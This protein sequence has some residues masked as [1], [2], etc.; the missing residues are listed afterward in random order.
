[1]STWTD[2]PRTFSKCIAGID[3]RIEWKPNHAATTEDAF[4]WKDSII[5]LEGLGD[6]TNEPIE[7]PKF[8]NFVARVGATMAQGWPGDGRHSGRQ[9]DPEEDDSEE[10]EE[11]SS[12]GGFDVNQADVCNGLPWGPWFGRY[13]TED[14]DYVSVLV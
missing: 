7:D 6:F 8:A 12:N 10:D 2:L 3:C 9:E 11:Q 14:D 13:F 4:V 5:K 1:M